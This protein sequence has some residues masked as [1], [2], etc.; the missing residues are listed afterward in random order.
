[1]PANTLFRFMAA[2][3]SGSV[4]INDTV[5]QVVSPHLPFGGVGPSGMGRYHGRKSFETFSNMRSVMAKSN[6]IDL[7]ARYPPYTP[8]AEKILRLIMR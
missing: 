3:Q 6:L 2:T 5:M 4:A 8:F 1:M 7:P